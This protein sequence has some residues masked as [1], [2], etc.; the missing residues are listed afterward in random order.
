MDKL[1]QT[2]K[3]IS[4]MRRNG[5][6]KKE[7]K[8]K[9]KKKKK[10]RIR[11]DVP[12]RQSSPFPGVVHSHCLQMH[13]ASPPCGIATGDHLPGMLHLGSHSKWHPL[14]HGQNGFT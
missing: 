8:K 3:F 2:L 7:K 6:E 1:I 9:R 13:R 14:K 11:K 4:T 12:H 5:G 10:E